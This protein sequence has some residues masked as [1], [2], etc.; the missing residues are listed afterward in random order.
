MTYLHVK[1][2]SMLLPV[3]YMLE[4]QIMHVCIIV[5]NSMF[6]RSN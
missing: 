3:V 5:K 6:L 2:I 1:I 4:L